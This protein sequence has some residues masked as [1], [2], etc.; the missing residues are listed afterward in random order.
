MYNTKI[1]PKLCIFNVFMM[2]RLF[3]NIKQKL[4]LFKLQGVDLTPV[5]NVTEEVLKIVD[6]ILVVLQRSS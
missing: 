4:Q 3:Y 1:R 2:L 5:V 6:V